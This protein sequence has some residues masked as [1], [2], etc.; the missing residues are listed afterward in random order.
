ME[1]LKLFSAVKQMKY[2]M[3][4]RY[5]IY[6]IFLT[7]KLTP[8]RVTDS[9]QRQTLWKIL[10]QVRLLRRLP[11]VSWLSGDTVTPERVAWL[12]LNCAGRRIRLLK[13]LF[14]RVSF[15]ILA[16]VNG[17]LIREILVLPIHWVLHKVLHFL[18]ENFI[19]VNGNSMTWFQS[20][21]V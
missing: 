5:F 8:A 14:V 20:R 3:S 21:L 9:L 19:V 11:H 6:F 4:Y 15:V 13:M 2:F 10:W 17:K 1:E 16:A 7:D 12:H 18:L